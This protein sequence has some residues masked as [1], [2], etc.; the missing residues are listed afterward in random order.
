MKNANSLSD[1]P[2]HARER[3]AAGI[4]ETPSGCHEY[5]IKAKRGYGHLRF[6]GREYAAHRV[7]WVIS[8]GPLLDTDVVI[9][10]VCENRS[11]VNP[12]HLEAVSQRANLLATSSTIAARN[13]T[14]THCIHGHEFTPANTIRTK[15]GRACRPCSR[16]AKARYREKK[17]PSLPADR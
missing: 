1:V 12:R 8:N 4:Q 3:L 7:A 5:R 10:H 9:H 2:L 17:S 6:A 15:T 11:C 13:S 14:K 16:E